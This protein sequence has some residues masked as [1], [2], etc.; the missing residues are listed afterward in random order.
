MCQNS[1]HPIGRGR[2]DKSASSAPSA[3]RSHPV[4]LECDKPQWSV[5]I[6]VPRHNHRARIAGLHFV[7]HLC[8]RRR[9]GTYSR[10]PRQGLHVV[11]N[12]QARFRFCSRLSQLRSGGVEF[13]GYGLE[14]RPLGQPAERC[15][16]V[17]Q[18]VAAV[19]GFDRGLGWSGVARPNSEFH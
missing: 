13:S 14:I 16:L 17:N 11:K 19:A 7:Q 3:F 5:D 4:P 2:V 12:Q 10:P 18:N 8:R 15:D 6:E 1:S 9:V